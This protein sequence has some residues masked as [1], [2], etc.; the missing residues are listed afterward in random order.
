VGCAGLGPGGHPGMA[1]GQIGGGVHMGLGY[2]LMEEFIQEEGL[3]RTPSFAEYQIP[4]V[5]DMPREIVP[6]IVEVAEPTGPYGA[7]GLGEMTTLP[8]APAV[9]SAIHDATGGWIT[10]LPATPEKV[11]ALVKSK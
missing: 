6:L 4:T 3:V 7:K 11:L 5:L 2:A 8:T 1:I 9:I 10:A